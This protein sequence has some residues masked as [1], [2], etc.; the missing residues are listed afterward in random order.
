M[1]Q[2][3]DDF[4]RPFIIFGFDTIFDMDS[5]NGPVRIP[6]LFAV[7]RFPTPGSCVLLLERTD[8][9]KIMLISCMLMINIIFARIKR[10]E[11]VMYVIGSRVVVCA[12]W[13]VRH[14]PLFICSMVRFSNFFLWIVYLWIGLDMVIFLNRIFWECLIFLYRVR[15]ENSYCNVYTMA[16]KQTSNMFSQFRNTIL[17]RELTMLILN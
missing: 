16:E 12:K 2:V 9:S 4:S 13:S 3:R 7:F 8:A 6:R 5:R 1:G 10:E 17:S 11:F 15:S 14:C